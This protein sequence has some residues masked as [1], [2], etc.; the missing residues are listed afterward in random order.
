MRNNTRALIGGAAVIGCAAGLIAGV[1]PATAAP[2]N[3]PGV[4][5][6]VNDDPA[7]RSNYLLRI[8]G[9]LPMSE[10]D[11]YDR[12]AHL[13]PGGG[14]DYIVYAD[15]PGDNDQPIGMPHGYPGA[16]G[17]AGGLVIAT[18]Y[19]LS[20]MREISVPRGDLDEDF[21][22]SWGCGDDTDEVYVKVRFVQGNGVPDLGAYT[23]PVSRKF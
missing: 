1:V 18:P 8:E 23:N 15:D 22:F 13:G 9:K 12:L 5:L 6:S 16:P 11:A 4:V 20:F 21:C 10:G 2:Q 19:G 17:P 7:N 3:S 14:M